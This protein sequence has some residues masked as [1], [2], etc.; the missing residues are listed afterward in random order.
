M[1]LIW[2]SSQ[3]Q[4]IRE[5]GGDI[6][7][8]EEFQT[9]EAR[10]K[11][12]SVLIE[13]LQSQHRKLIRDLSVNP[14]RHPL[15]ELEDSLA[16]MLVSKGFLEVKTPTI[17]SYEA[18]RKM[19]IDKEHLLY[20]QVFWLD[21]KR[22]LRPMLAP[23]LYFLMRQL[24]RNV[25]MPLMMFE[26]GTCYRKESHGNSHLEEFTMLNLVEMKPS[27]DAMERLKEHIV[28]VM[29]QVGL[30]Y[31]LVTAKSEVYVSTIDVE[32]GGVEVASGAVGPHVLDK[33]HGITDPWAGV[34]FGLE[35]LLLMKSG[36]LNIKKVG[37][38]L[39]YL[40]GARI[41]I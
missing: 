11:A 9:E 18:L 34:G 21:E 12:F 7:Q 41:D 17:I 36:D 10:E 5:L 31:E 23:N 14:R 25:K 35:R 3:S 6:S 33:A 38:S 32:V 20:E 1:P 22:C 40:N 24:K 13:K 29:D 39:I 26:I 8:I 27:T 28:S 4:R 19:G 16:N 30:E 2:T 37:R 15:A